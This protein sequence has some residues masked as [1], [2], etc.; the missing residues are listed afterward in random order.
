MKTLILFFSVLFLFSNIMIADSFYDAAY[1]MKTT[2]LNSFLKQQLKPLYNEDEDKRED[3]FEGFKKAVG[4]SKRQSDKMIPYTILTRFV[5]SEELPVKLKSDEDYMEDVQDLQM[6]ALAFLIENVNNDD[7]STGDREFLMEQL[8]LIATTINTSNFDFIQ[9]SADAVLESGSTDNAV[10][11]HTAMVVA[12]AFAIKDDEEWEDLA[13]SSAQLIGSDMENSDTDLQRFSFFVSLDTI[14]IAQSKTD[15]IVHLWEAIASNYEEITSPVL[16]STVKTAIKS[17]IKSNTGDL[18]KDEIE[19]IKEALDDEES[20][21]KLN[22]Q[23]LDELFEEINDV[24]DLIELEAILDRLTKLSQS[25]RVI[26]YQIYQKLIEQSLSSESSLF[27]LRLIN[28]TIIKLA[29]NTKSPLFFYRT[30]MVFL[31][32]IA[33]FGNDIKSQIPLTMLNSLLSS[34]EY[35]Q[36]T[37]PVMEEINTFLNFSLPIWVK[38]R[39]VTTIYVQAGNSPNP[40]VAD[41]ALKI[42]IDIANNYE[43]IALRFDTLTRIQQLQK[44]ASIKSVKA[45][46]NK[47]LRGN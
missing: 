28:E 17:L 22:K 6:E 21:K 7:L 37:K 34:T 1:K 26:L 8:A 41:A 47:W 16:Q 46:S 13:E 30:A 27:K 42:L 3:S 23:P 19:E 38:R 20:L 18:F 15:A 12:K 32:E 35:L 10:L 36:L 31:S 40:E 44:F 25:N 4:Q 9:K 45:Q 33:Q 5:L 39:L 24:D 2:E 14:K 11:K 29:H 43:T